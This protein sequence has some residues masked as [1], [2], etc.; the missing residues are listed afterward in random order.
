[1]ILDLPGYL[2]HGTDRPAG[3]GMRVSHGCI[4]MLPNDIEDLIYRVPVGTSV[5]LINQPVKFGWDAAGILNVQAFP[6]QGAGDGSDAHIDEAL[7]A[8]TRAA[9]DRRFLVD[10]RRLKKQL[11]TP[12]GMPVALLLAERPFP[13]P[14][15]TLTFFER[16]QLIPSLYSRVSTRPVGEPQ[17]QTK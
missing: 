1:M 12:D 16:A 8:A 3:V 6:A 15:P 17:A 4:R 5:R 11:E 7:D 10:Y 14:E 2:I 9:S 13:L